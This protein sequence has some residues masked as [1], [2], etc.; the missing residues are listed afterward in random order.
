MEVGMYK[1]KQIRSV[2]EMVKSEQIAPLFHILSIT[3]SNKILFNKLY[4]LSSR[5]VSASPCSYFIPIKVK[6]NIQKI[7]FMNFV[8]L[9]TKL[10]KGTKSNNFVIIFENFLTLIWVG[11][12]GL[13]LR[14]EVRWR[15]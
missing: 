1:I 2:L 7:L 10:Y 8:S 9:I 6:L 15:R 5:F 11:F 3:V 12:L 4:Q 13:V 14:W